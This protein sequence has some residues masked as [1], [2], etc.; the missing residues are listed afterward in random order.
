MEGGGPA[1]RQTL[2]RSAAREWTL[3][4]C[5]LRAELTEAGID[6]ELE[7][8]LDDGDR[9][10][11]ALVYKSWYGASPSGLGSLDTCIASKV[12]RQRMVAAI[13]LRIDLGRVNVY[14]L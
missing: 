13:A 10:V 5:P 1:P 3:G 9:E 2:L 11:G 7:L 6:G 12:I 4:W 14:L 8:D